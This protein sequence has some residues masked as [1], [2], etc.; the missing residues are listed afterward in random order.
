MD[1]PYFSSPATFTIPAFCYSHILLTLQ[2]GRSTNRQT[3]TY[4]NL[5]PLSTSPLSVACGPL[6]ERD[7]FAPAFL[8]P[9]PSI[10]QMHHRDGGKVQSFAETCA[11]GV[12]AVARETQGQGGQQTGYSDE[13]RSKMD[14]RGSKSSTSKKMRVH[15]LS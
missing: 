7:I 12:R 8:W 15:R 10:I 6:R 11:V 9:R 1:K 4:C 5:A 14:G 13:R 2:P 3:I